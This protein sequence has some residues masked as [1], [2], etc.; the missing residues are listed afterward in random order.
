MDEGSKNASEAKVKGVSD[1]NG[2]FRNLHVNRRCKSYGAQRTVT[3]PCDCITVCAA[4]TYSVDTRCFILQEESCYPVKSYDARHSR[5][6]SR[7]Q[8]VVAVLQLRLQRFSAIITV[9]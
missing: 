3:G 7:I 1:V 8:R 5:N 2:A 9:V 6:S 4:F